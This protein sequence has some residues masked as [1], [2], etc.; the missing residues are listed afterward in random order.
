MK[1][2]FKFQLYFWVS[3]GYFVVRKCF[4]GPQEKQLHLL[5]KG[6]KC[7]SCFQRVIIPKSRLSCPVGIFDIGCCYR[8]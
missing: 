3:Y 6:L 5:N 2:P 1:I 8:R 4:P 7:T